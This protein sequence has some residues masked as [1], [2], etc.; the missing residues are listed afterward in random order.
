MDLSVILGERIKDR[1]LLRWVVRFTGLELY[2]KLYYG[3]MPKWHMS[4]SLGVF[5]CVR[6]G[7]ITKRQKQPPSW[8]LFLYSIPFRVS[9]VTAL[10]RI[11]LY[12]QLVRT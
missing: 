5:C 8:R 3:N 12:P 6:P 10:V 7:S 11:T 9:S 4:T 1:I 2:I